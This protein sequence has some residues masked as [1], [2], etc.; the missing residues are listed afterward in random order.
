[1]NQRVGTL[2]D[3]TWLA[4]A[5]LS[6]RIV[7]STDLNS[8]EQSLPVDLSQLFATYVSEEAIWNERLTAIA[9]SSAGAA[10]PFLGRISQV[11]GQPAK[12][13]VITNAGDKYGSGINVEVQFL[14][15]QGKIL[16]SAATE[17]E[18]DP[19]GEPDKKLLELK[20][21]EK[22]LE[23]PP[24]DKVILQDLMAKLGGNDTKVKFIPISPDLLKR[25]KRP[26]FNEPLAGY[27]SQLI[28]GAA[29]QQNLNVVADLPDIYLMTVGISAIAGMPTARGLLGT[30]QQMPGT[31]S[32]VKFEGVWMEVD[33][34]AFA[35]FYASRSD[36]EALA[37]L[38][39]SWNGG[40]F[41]T[42]ALA[43]Y[44]LRSGAASNDFMAT[45][46]GRL[47]S[48]AVPDPG[49]LEWQTL[50]LLGA[51][52][53]EFGE[54]I[55]QS[56]SSEIPFNRLDPDGRRILA[57]TVYSH[58]FAQETGAPTEFRGRAGGATQE[59]EELFPNGLPADGKIQVVVKTE[60]RV[61]MHRPGERERVESIR[62]VAQM[63]YNRDH[64]DP[65]SG[66]PSEEL[67]KAVFALSTPSTIDVSLTIGSIFHPLESVVQHDAGEATFVSYDKLP[68]TF[69]DEV[70]KIVATIK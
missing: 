53:Q 36:R 40:T 16:K 65:N 6:K 49:G 51:L 64:P 18:L 1:M 19:D 59:P 47:L 12:A 68:Q 29:E 28:L 7:F 45:V 25:F 32:P 42:A 21:D 54:K 4:N 30:L 10:H 22:R 2:F 50:R 8:M 13:L 15:A 3:P 35:G 20:G 60:D 48:D 69:K 31:V 37:R 58:A 61:I 24:D 52:E 43:D 14:D 17:Y 66:R 55:L 70:Q 67:S 56:P 23:V 46:L 41:S 57:E 38:F 11:V 44:A 63:V 5:S 27:V 26:D 34:A 39:T 9:T 33:G 62:G